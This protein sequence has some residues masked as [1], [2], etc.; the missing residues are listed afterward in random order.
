MDRRRIIMQDGMYAFWH[1]TGRSMADG[2]AIA[3]RIVLDKDHKGRDLEYCS[4][5]IRYACCTRF[6]VRLLDVAL[7]LLSRLNARTT[8]YTVWNFI[9]VN[10]FMQLSRPANFYFVC[11]AVLQVQFA[12]VPHDA[13]FCL[14]GDGV[15]R[16]SVP[17]R[18]LKVAQP[19]CF[20]SASCS[21]FLPSRTRTKTAY[22]TLFKRPC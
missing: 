16:P 11:I 22:V 19:S 2:F 17:Y 14:I 5:E 1:R 20:H 10:L 21:L 3:G 18:L 9:P 15:C 4:N 6:M 12:S 7:I 13:S 8:K